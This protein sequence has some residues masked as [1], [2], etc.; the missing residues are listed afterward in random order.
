MNNGEKNQQQSISKIAQ[1][2]M[3]NDVIQIILLTTCRN[4]IVNMKLTCKL[5]LFFLFGTQHGSMCIQLNVSIK[6]SSF[7]GYD[8]K[9]CLIQ[10]QT[11]LTLWLIYLTEKK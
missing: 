6:G 9:K 8:G 11:V 1:F 4:T 3:L 7:I 2:H 5:N 10:N